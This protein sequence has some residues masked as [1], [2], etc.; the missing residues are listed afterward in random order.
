MRI[1]VT[2]G[3]GQLARDCRQVLQ[4]DFDLI[5]YSH[6][7]LDITQREHIDRV[8]EKES[9]ELILN[10]AAYNQVDDCETHRELAYQSNVLGPKLL[11]VAAAKIKAPLIHISTN[12]VFDGAKPLPQGYVEEDLPAP[13]SY[14]GKT[15]WE[16]EQA[17]REISPRN[18]VIRTAWLYGIHGWNF[19]KT[20][21]KSAAQG[22]PIPINHDQFGSFTWTHRLAQQIKRLIGASGHGLY[23]ATAEGFSSRYEMAK[24]L[25]E[26]LGLKVE[27][28]PCPSN[29][30]KAAAARPKNSILENQRLKSEGIDIM[31]PWEEDLMKFIMDHKNELLKVH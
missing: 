1:L 21:I 15:K 24:L 23:H 17:V 19:P 10:C 20:L 18:L 3:K 25:F 14:Y 28:T 22:K 13:L 5:P 26:K 11:A 2:G 12:Y 31:R 4:D 30:F 9:P 7:D 8:L 29:F 27:L 16:G 6:Q